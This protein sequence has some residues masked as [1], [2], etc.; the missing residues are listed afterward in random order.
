MWVMTNSSFVSI[1]QHWDKPDIMVVRGRFLGDVANFLNLPLSAEKVTPDNDY[2]F[3]IEATRDAVHAAVNRAVTMIDY[4]NFKNSCPPWRHAVYMGVWSV[5][6][7][8]QRVALSGT[9]TW[10]KNLNRMVY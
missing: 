3:R 8:A 10:W 1:V 2:R 6:H 4:G 7:Q 9:K 5:L